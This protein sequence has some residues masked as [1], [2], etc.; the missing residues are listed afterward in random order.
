MLS[1]EAQ[2][3]LE[4]WLHETPH[5]VVVECVRT[6]KGIGWGRMLSKKG[7]GGCSPSQIDQAPWSMHTHPS[8]CY[9]RNGTYFGWPSGADYATVLDQ[10]AKEHLVCAIEGIYVL[11]PTR[12]AAGR[13][14]RLSA[15]AQRAH[16]RQW[17]VASDTPDRTPEDVLA[18]LAPHLEGWVAVEYHPYS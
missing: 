1:P 7:S 2:R 6:P 17:D 18:A 11:H 12:G 9:L 5:E 3:Q 10:D 13:W 15:K 16:E 8:A 4:V 14:R